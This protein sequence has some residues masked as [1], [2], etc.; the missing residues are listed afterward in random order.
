MPHTDSPSFSDPPGEHHT[1]IAKILVCVLYH[2]PLYIFINDMIC[3]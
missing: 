3:D 1:C 2:R